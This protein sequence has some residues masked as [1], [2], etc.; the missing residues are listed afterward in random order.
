MFY[1][2]SIRAWKLQSFEV[3]RNIPLRSVHEYE[4][5]KEGSENYK[6]R[7]SERQLSFELVVFFSNLVY[8]R[9]SNELGAKSEGPEG[10]GMMC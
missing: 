4:L 6:R 1:K 7:E 5:K 3:I 8:C 2:S 9:I 10:D